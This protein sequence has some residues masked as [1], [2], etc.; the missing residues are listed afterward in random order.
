MGTST[1]RK[2]ATTETVKLPTVKRRIAIRKKAELSQ[3]QLAALVGI[4]PMTMN[5]AERG[6]INLKPEN[7]AKYAAALAK[8]QQP[9]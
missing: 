9:N 8:L 2:K 1:S 3:T 5:R 6:V 4:A 7:A